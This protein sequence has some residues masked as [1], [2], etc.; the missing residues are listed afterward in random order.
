[1][2]TSPKI[3]RTKKIIPKTNRATSRQFSRIQPT[4]SAIANATRQEARVIKKAI[5]LRRPLTLMAGIV[6][7]G[8][9][10]KAGEVRSSSNRGRRQGV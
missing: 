2:R 8:R 9:Q 6:T 5:D 3:I 10:R 7:G 4:F 1:L